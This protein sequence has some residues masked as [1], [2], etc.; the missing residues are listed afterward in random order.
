M[1]TIL[2]GTGRVLPVEQKDLRINTHMVVRLEMWFSP[3]NWKYTD[4]PE[5]VMWRVCRIFGV[6]A[7]GTVWNK[8]GLPQSYWWW[9]TGD[10]VGPGWLSTL[11]RCITVRLQAS[12][13]GTAC[14]F[15]QSL[16]PDFY[17]GFWLIKQA[18]EYGRVNWGI[19]SC[20]SC[21][22]SLFGSKMRWR[23]EREAALL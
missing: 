16:L 18:R 10:G 21:P 2:C 8:W 12:W 3:F 5:T 1:Y 9:R 7:L 20:D 15:I 19:F 23:A 17:V 4:P 11:K 14:L 6:N 13:W 22:A